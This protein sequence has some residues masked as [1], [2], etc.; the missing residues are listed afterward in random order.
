MV[1]VREVQLAVVRVNCGG[2]MMVI[3]DPEGTYIEI[4]VTWFVFHAVLSSA[5]VVYRE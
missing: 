1:I 3:V 2:K 5:E 4:E